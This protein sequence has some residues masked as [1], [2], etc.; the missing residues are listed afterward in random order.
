MTSFVLVALR[1]SH[2][3]GLVS[4]RVGGTGCG[5]GAGAGAG[6]EFLFVDEEAH[7][8]LAAN[9]PRREL[10]FESGSP[11]GSAGE[12]GLDSSSGLLGGGESSSLFPARLTSS[13]DDVDNR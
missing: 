10:C 3:K 8:K 1:E 4:F 5:A 6:G 12:L 7:G 13:R 2:E 9:P 11:D